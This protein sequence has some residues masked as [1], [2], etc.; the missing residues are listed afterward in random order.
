M[1]EEAT[2]SVISR[3]EFLKTLS[4]AGLLV[5]AGGVL[6]PATAVAEKTQDAL[7]AGRP[8]VRYPEKT[9][10]LLLTSRPPRLETP[11]SYFARA[12]TPNAAFFV[13]YHVTPIPTAVDP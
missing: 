7:L 12:I 11:M 1:D 6:A 5:T 13:R 10:L 2:M 8:L 4:R 9:E 3:R